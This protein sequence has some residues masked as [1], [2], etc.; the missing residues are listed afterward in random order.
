MLGIIW[1]ITVNCTGKSICEFKNNYL[2]FNLLYKFIVST[3]NEFKSYAGASS[4]SAKKRLAMYLYSFSDRNT[5]RGTRLSKYI[6]ELKD[7]HIE[8]NIKWEMIIKAPSYRINM[9]KYVLFICERMAIMK[10]R[11]QNFKPEAR[12]ATSMTT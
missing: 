8:Y 5:F 10:G 9:R 3:S 1:V 7:K 6:Y 12:I 4:N 11:S 2:K